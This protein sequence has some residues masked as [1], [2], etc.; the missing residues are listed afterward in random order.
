M[1]LFPETYDQ[2]ETEFL[3][4]INDPGSGAYSLCPFITPGIYNPHH[5]QNGNSGDC[6][7]LPRNIYGN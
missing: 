4:F 6:G 2:E 7:C 1:I 3:P 5:A